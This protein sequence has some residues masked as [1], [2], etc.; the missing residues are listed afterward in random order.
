MLD[1]GKV[2]VAMARWSSSNFLSGREVQL[3]V[4]QSVQIRLWQ[5]WEQFALL[6]RACDAVVLLKCSLDEFELVF[7]ADIH[8]SDDQVAVE[9]DSTEMRW[10]DWI[11]PGCCCH[12]LIQHLIDVLLAH[13]RVDLAA[14]VWVL[15]QSVEYK[16][17]CKRL[18]SQ[19]CVQ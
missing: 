16:G 4:R 10:N 5:G 6:L 11:Q 13:H 9:A 17:G 7:N 15:M 8:V 3:L 19:A 1:F 2:V 12:L 18:S 14:N